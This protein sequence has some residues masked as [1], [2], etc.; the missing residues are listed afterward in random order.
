VA[1]AVGLFGVAPAA[2]AGASMA[3]AGWRVAVDG[4]VGGA[5]T[6]LNGV[7]CVGPADCVAVGDAGVDAL[8]EH[9]SGHWAPTQDQTVGRITRGTLDTVACLSAAQCWAAG[10]TNAPGS[11]DQRGL[12]EEQTA[13]GWAPVRVATA[14]S[15]W[16]GL[17][18]L[19]SAKTC[20]AVGTGPL[21]D[22]S[23]G[24]AV[25]IRWRAGVWSQVPAPTTSDGLPVILL[26]VSCA[27]ANLCVAAG[28]IG[29]QGLADQPFSEVWN[30][31][32]WRAVAL[33]HLGSTVETS[34]TSVS[35]VATK[36]RPTCTAVGYDYTSLPPPPGTVGVILPLIDRFNGTTWVTAPSPAGRPEHYPALAAV[37]CLS[38]AFCWAAGTQGPGQDESDTLAEGWNG[39]TWTWATTP[40]PVAE[41]R[42]FT[43]VACPD[44]AQCWAVGNTSNGEGGEDQ[45]IAQWRS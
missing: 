17:T 14:A 30:G 23:S 6:L 41:Y 21:G 19:T 10:S 7:T 9:Y 13:S 25:I 33:E 42:G 29:K 11:A 3:P 43:S 1:L 35:C 26:S 34:F 2:A 18:C 38:S 20:W 44:L 15:T 28:G 31:R 32:T 4:R 5:P 24:H 40:D 22:T 36:P 12:I 37:T 45:L 39:R 27:G 16:S 8:V